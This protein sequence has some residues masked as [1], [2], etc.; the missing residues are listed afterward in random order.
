MYFV[1]RLMHIGS[2]KNNF[3]NT[4]LRLI[5]T[6]WFPFFEKP[7]FYFNFKEIQILYNYKKKYLLLGGIRITKK[8]IASGY[9]HD[10]TMVI[11]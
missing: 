4:N 5:N 6:S 10:K 2:V 7:L 11:G 8:G 1:D 3:K 9:L